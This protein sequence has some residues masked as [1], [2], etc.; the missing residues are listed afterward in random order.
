MKKKKIPL[1]KLSSIF[2]EI[3]L[4]VSSSHHRLVAWKSVYN[5]KRD[6]VECWRRSEHGECH[7]EMREVEGGGERD[8]SAKHYANQ[9]EKKIRHE[10][11]ILN[12]FR[13]LL[14]LL[15]LVQT[16]SLRA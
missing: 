6:D 16:H 3:S 10:M 5:A 14:L 4:I 13:S 7:G 9:L 11:E 2:I 15:L 8:Q 12:P 1:D